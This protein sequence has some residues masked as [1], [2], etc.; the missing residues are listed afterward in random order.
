MQLNHGMQLTPDGKTLFASTID[1]VYSWSYN[2]KEMKTTSPPVTW[3]D[4]M[5][6]T[7]HTTRTLLIPKSA[8]GQLLVSRGSGSNI[9]YRALNISSG[10]SQIR[11]FDISG[12]PKTYHYAS[13]GKLI[14]WG[15]RNSV[16][17]A[18]HPTTGGIW[19]NENGSDDMKRDGKDIHETSPGSYHSCCIASSSNC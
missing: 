6:N 16:G 4:G 12:S 3:V 7:D 19:S 9:D 1:K 18:E 14:G 11:S 2:A 17:M 10:I 13:D 5:Q 15:L 8:P